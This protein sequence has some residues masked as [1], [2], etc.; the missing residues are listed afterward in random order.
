MTKELL[1]EKIK[2]LKNNEALH[3]IERILEI[4]DLES[5]NDNKFS[6]TANE[7]ALIKEAELALETGQ[8]YSHKE[9]LS[10]AETWFEK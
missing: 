6:F 9:V 8:A 3:D 1:I 4:Y 2:E 5:N 10:I 7:I